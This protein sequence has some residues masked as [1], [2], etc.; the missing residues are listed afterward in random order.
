MRKVR[1]PTLARR[2]RDCSNWPMVERCFWTRSGTCRL[3]CRP[4]SC[5]SSRPT[6]FGG[7]AERARSPWTYGSSPPPTRISRRRS[8]RAV[9]AGTS[10]I[11]STS[12]PCSCRRCANEETTSA[13]WPRAWSISIPGEFKKPVRRIDE[14]VMDK[15]RRHDWPGNVRELRNVIER[16]VLLAKSDALTVRDIVLGTGGEG[17]EIDS[18]AGMNLPPTGLD[19]EELEKKLLRQALGPHRRQPEP[20][21]Q[22][23]WFLAR[24]LPLP[25]G[26]TRAAVSRASV[27]H[28]FCVSHP[29]HLTCRPRCG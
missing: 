7:W 15:L 4:S 19:F 5:T 3:R 23:P 8:R 27:P 12:C 28:R 16:A 18:L 21:G 2:R 10:C 17:A 9:S 25:A 6:V 26:E 20:S 24:H 11:G 29:P 13:C 1:S 14:A 22:A